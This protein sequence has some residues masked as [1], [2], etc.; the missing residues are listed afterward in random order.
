MKQMINTLGLVSAFV[1]I[2]AIVAHAHT[3]VLG[4]SPIFFFILPTLLFSWQA[5]SQISIKG[6]GTSISR[7]RKR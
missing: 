2:T 1:G 4:L 5:S 7:K 6:S 3:V